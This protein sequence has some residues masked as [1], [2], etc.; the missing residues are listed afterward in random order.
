MLLSILTSGIATA[1]NANRSGF[2]MELGIGGM[3]GDTPLSSISITDNVVYYKCLTGAAADFGLGGR[4]RF[5]DHWAYEIKA[6]AQIPLDNP[7]NALVGRALPI[8]FRYISG[9]L[10]RNYSIYAHINLGGAVSV[11]RGI[12]GRGNI[13][14]NSSDNKNIIDYIKDHGWEDGV[15][16]PDL[17]TSDLKGYVGLEGYGVAYSLGIGVNITT[18]LYL[19]GCLNAQSI[20]G[21]YGKDG[22]GMLNYGNASCVIGYRF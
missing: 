12:I 3:V 10:W 5:A 6:E 18:H 15:L 16:T 2:F 13:D 11:N 20:I 19:E 9:E 7:V 1:Q 21:G 8:G 17:P 14:F 4:F 22:K